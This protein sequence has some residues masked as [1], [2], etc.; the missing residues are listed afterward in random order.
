MKHIETHWNHK[1]PDVIKKLVTL[2]AL[3]QK[4]I[5]CILNMYIIVIYIYIYTLEQ[6]P[7][8]GFSLQ[9]SNSAVKL[10]VGEEFHPELGDVV[11]PCQ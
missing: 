5:K 3:G 7:A 8:L 9:M 2:L 1:H 4:Q 11:A 6:I 10:Q